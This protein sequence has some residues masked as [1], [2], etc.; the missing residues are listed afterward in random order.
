MVSH[1][2]KKWSNVFLD[3]AHEST[4]NKDVKEVVTS[5]S[6][7]SI[8]NKMH[9]LPF[10]ANLVKQFLKNTRVASSKVSVSQDSFSEAKLNEENVRSIF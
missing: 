4:I 5:A 2:G 7:F 1:S 9:Y 3:E 6:P 8:S 10:R